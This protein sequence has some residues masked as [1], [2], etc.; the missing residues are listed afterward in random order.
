MPEGRPL[1]HGQN[2]T[3]DFLSGSPAAFWGKRLVPEWVFHVC[4]IACVAAVTNQSRASRIKHSLILPQF[5]ALA[6]QVRVAQLCPLLRVSPGWNQDARRAVFLSGGSETE[7]TSKLTRTVGLFQFLAGVRQSP[8]SLLTASWSLLWEAASIPSQAFLV[9][10]C[11]PAAVSQVPFM[12]RISPK[13]PFGHITGRGDSS[14]LL[15]APLIWLGP[16]R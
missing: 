15:R 3:V 4:V 12:L 7:L 5:H 10:Y 6:A 13:F 11:P 8:I 16:D 14:L 2:G 1:S 9:P